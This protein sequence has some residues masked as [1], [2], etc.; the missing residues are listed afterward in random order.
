MFQ[1]SASGGALPYLP[2]LSCHVS[3]LM[4][5]VCLHADVVLLWVQR[6][7]VLRVRPDAGLSRVQGVPALRAPH[8]QVGRGEVEGLTG[9]MPSCT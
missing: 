4:V 2:H 1:T 7:G 5:F 3:I 9:V 6:T 8:L